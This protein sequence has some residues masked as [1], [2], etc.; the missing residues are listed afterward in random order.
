[1][2]DC[3]RMRRLICSVGLVLALGAASA[4]PPAGAVPL[5]VGG[6]PAAAGQ[7]PWIVAIIRKGQDAFQGQFCGGTVIA[8]QAVVTAAHCVGGERASGLQVLANQLDLKGRGGQRVRV[9]RGSIQAR[10][11]A[12]TS[13]HVAGGLLLA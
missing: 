11:N 1:M 3:S 9:A 5:V 10:Y 6:T 13:R 4:V 8:P 7:V 12:N 2:A